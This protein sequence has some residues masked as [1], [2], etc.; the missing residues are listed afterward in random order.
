[1][2]VIKE[3][4][5]EV[6]GSKNKVQLYGK[7]NQLLCRRH[8]KQMYRYNKITDSRKSRDDDILFEYEDYAV[9]KLYSKTGEFI[10]DVFIDKEDVP[11]AM[12]YKWCLTK[13]HVSTSDDKNKTIYLHRLV[14]R[15]ENF[16]GEVID[17]IDGNPLNNRKSNLRICTQHQNVLNHRVARNNTSG[18]TG[19]T[20]DRN[21]NK[22]ASQIV[23]NGKNHHLGRYENIE[24][25]INAR[26]KAE[27]KLFK[28]F[29]IHYEKN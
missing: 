23:Y 22:W 18:V 27:L 14:M 9:I 7:T 6:C 8:R 20:W 15:L 3:K 17:H 24:D 13:G 21:R 2:I 10:D 5:C 11:L 26:I 4:I 25:A 1:M 19:V 28:E 16:N 12:Q 29:S